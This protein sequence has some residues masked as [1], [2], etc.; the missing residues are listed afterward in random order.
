MPVLVTGAEDALGSL[1]V[2]Q[3]RASGGEV[4]VY[5]DA[6]AVGRSDAARLR[7]AGC[8]VALGE[9]DDEGHLEAAL[10]QT[11]TVAHCWGGPLRDRDD[12]VVAA[13]TVASAALGAGVRR[14]IWVRELADSADNAFLAALDEI[15]DLFDALPMETVTLATGVRHGE[16]DTLTAR[17]ARGWLAGTDA[18]LTT[19]HAPVGL[20]DVAR[21]V[22]LADRQRGAL[23]E[24]HVRMALV[25]P[26]RMTLGTF[27]RRLRTARAGAT[28]GD[29]HGAG[30]P[31]DAPPPPR[32]LV[33]WLSTPAAE[34]LERARDGAT[35]VVARGTVRLPGAVST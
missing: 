35:P 32:W 17:L 25:G 11:H 16:H 14:F 8:K 10:A 3:L 13:A 12:Q 31:T 9:L 26:E 21:A 6:T 19:V 20:T 23:R 30:V 18:D 29:D 34:P 7:A 2:D 22:V 4:R 5:L 15:D 28:H 27:V 24:A 1:V 33:D